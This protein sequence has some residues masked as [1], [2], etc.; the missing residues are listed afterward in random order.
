MGLLICSSCI[1]RVETSDVVGSDGL[2]R[3]VTVIQTSYTPRDAI[4]RAA[5]VLER[6]QFTPVK[7]PNY[8]A[9]GGWFSSAP[10]EWPIVYDAYS[11][12]AYARTAAGEPIGLSA[13]WQGMGTTTL[14]VT[15]Q[16]SAAQHAN[17]VEQ[18]QQEFD[19]GHSAK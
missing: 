14:K 1:S 10:K 7:P 19:R 18:I 3:H 12:V 13:T 9:P 11:G 6:M 4:K 16:L 2:T 17:L 15:T 8:S 5:N